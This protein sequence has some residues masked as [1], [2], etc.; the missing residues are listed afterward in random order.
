[1]ARARAEQKVDIWQEL[2]VVLELELEL[3]LELGVVCKLFVNCSSYCNIPYYE[4]LIILSSLPYEQ[5]LATQ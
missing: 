5:W 4:L 3:G 1:M 2:G